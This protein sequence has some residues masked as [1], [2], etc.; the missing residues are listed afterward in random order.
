MIS[1]LGET[2]MTVQETTD[3]TP[4]RSSK[5]LLAWMIVS[6]ILSVLIILIAIGFGIF[7]ELI[8]GGVLTGGSFTLIELVLFLPPFFLIPIIASW[9]VYKKGR[10]TAALVLTS[11]T[12]FVLACPFLVGVLLIAFSS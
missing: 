12:F 8:G 2:T 1:S 5:K 3:A 7:V 6:Q 11:V 9:V 4:K 10:L